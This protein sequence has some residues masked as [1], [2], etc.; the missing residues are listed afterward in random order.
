[1]ANEKSPLF[2][3]RQQVEELTSLSRS[4]LYRLIDRGAF[5]A[6]VQLSPGRSVWVASEVL[7]WVETRI[8]APRGEAA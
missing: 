1:M 6:Q 4:T 8:A 7:S 5:P 3:S 2:L